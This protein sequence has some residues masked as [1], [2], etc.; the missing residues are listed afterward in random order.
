MMAK[1]AAPPRAWKKGQSGNPKGRPRGPRILSEALRE[2]LASC[3]LD[4]KRNPGDQT[5]ASR[6]AESVIKHLIETRD[7]HLLQEILERLEGRVPRPADLLPLQVPITDVFS[8]LVGALSNGNP[9]EAET[10]S[11]SKE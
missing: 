4:G 3:E 6:V 10:E 2:V 11:A 1:R 5:N 8:R 7:V 9:P